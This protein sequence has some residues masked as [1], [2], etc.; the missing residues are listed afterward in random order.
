LKPKVLHSYLL[1]AYLPPFFLTLFIGVFVFFLIQVF[2]YLDD[3]VGKGME[4]WVLCQFFGYTFL[5]FIP[6]AMPL[7]VLLS[8]IM[9]FGNLA[10]N[11]E[12]AAMK[13]SG[14]SLFKIMRPIF[15]FILFLAAF[16]FAFNNFTLPH[17]MLKSAR[18]LWDIRQA[19]P[20]L[21]IK[22]GIYYSQLDG[23][24]IKV[25]NKSKDGQTLYNLSIYDHSDGMGNNVQLYADSGK[26]KTSVDTNYLQ[27][28]LKNGYRY[29]NVMQE[30]QHKRTRPLMQLI[31]KELN[32]NVDM[33]SFKMKNTEEALFNNNYQM[34]DIWQISNEVDTMNL[35]ISK[36][37]HDLYRQ[38][39]NYFLT[40]TLRTA[41][42]EKPTQPVLTFYSTLNKDEY[43]RSI[44]NTKNLVRSSSS[45]IDSINDEI[46]GIEYKKLEFLVGWH[47]K[48]TV[49][50][51]CIILFFVGASLGA[52]IRKG[53]MGLPVVVAVL[54]FLLY[55]IVSI[56]YE[57][58]VLEGV[59][60]IVF[61]SWFPLLLF[62][63]LGIFLTYKAARDSALFDLTAYLNPIKKLFKS[64]PKS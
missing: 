19:K 11:Y 42:L 35:D 24:S 55:Y 29:E 30:E 5:S 39:S 52:I 57:R 45:F 34:M 49:S 54:F 56:I 41:S 32:I 33:S 48:I 61:G 22:E 21:S 63:P 47:K 62:L 50:F 36:K 9:T 40:R 17:I 6:V 12:L 25:G 14:L 7:A 8:S 4:P 10:E 13:S 51:A 18:L 3:I 28:Q 37:H 23:Y 2:T 20:T 44:E 53:G 60:T 59:Y 46:I 26:M 64:S 27:L 38:F 15:V 58:L 1:K 43:L 31:Y 16:T